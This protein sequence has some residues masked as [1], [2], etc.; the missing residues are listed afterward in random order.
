M[1]SQQGTRPFT[2]K[3]SKNALAPLSDKLVNLFAQI[4]EE[5]GPLREYEPV[6]CDC[7]LTMITFASQSNKF[8]NTFLLP[9]DVST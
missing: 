9:V 2:G 1:K 4:M 6:L 5:L 7:L 3:S 8:K